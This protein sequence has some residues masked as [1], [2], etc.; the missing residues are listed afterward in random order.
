MNISGTTASS[1]D[2]PTSTQT[3]SADIRSYKVDFGLQADIPIN[4]KIS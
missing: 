1:S 3:Y 2:V 4:K